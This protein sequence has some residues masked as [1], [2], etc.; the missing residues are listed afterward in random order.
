MTKSSNHEFSTYTT[1]LAAGV[2]EFRGVD[3]PVVEKR[4]TRRAASTHNLRLVARPLLSPVPVLAE[5]TY[6]PLKSRLQNSGQP[7][8]GQAQESTTGKLVFPRGYPRRK[9]GYMPTLAAGDFNLTATRNEV[10][11][12]QLTA[13]VSRTGM[14]RLSDSSRTRKAAARR[15]WLPSIHFMSAWRNKTHVKAGSSQGYGIRYVAKKST[16]TNRHP[17]VLTCA[18]CNC[19]PRSPFNSNANL[20]PIS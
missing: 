19:L 11:T 15:L 1:S 12:M 4:V 18:D 13:L 9:S 14:V 6:K 7:R 20:P 10:T 3:A 17:L 8:S 16:R 5:I 2:F